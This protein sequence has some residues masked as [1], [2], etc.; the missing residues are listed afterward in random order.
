M[1]EMVN[2]TDFGI[3]KR[4]IPRFDGFYL[5]AVRSDLGESFAQVN[6]YSES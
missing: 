4:T 5:T 6:N 3:I 2:R 1:A